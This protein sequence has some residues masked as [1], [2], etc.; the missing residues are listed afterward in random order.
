MEITNNNYQISN[1]HQNR[2]T[3]NQTIG[4]RLDFRYLN[5]GIY[6]FFEI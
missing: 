2:I 3:K 1:K 6:L 4:K 5:I